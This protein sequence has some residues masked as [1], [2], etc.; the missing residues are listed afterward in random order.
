MKPETIRKI[1]DIDPRMIDFFNGIQYS[2]LNFNNENLLKLLFVLEDKPGKRISS[3]SK[4]DA[5]FAIKNQMR[6]K[7]ILLCI[8]TFLDDARLYCYYLCKARSIYPLLCIAYHLFNK[9][10][11]SFCESEEYWENNQDEFLSFKFWLYRFL[12]F[13]TDNNKKVFVLP[14]EGLLHALNAHSEELKL[15]TDDLDKCNT[16]F[17][18]Y[19]ING[20]TLF[21]KENYGHFMYPYLL[22]SY[23]YSEYDIDNVRNIEIVEE[24]DSL[25]LREVLSFVER[26]NHF[27]VNKKLYITNSLIP[28][29]ED[30]WSEERFL[31]FCEARGKLIAEKV[32]QIFLG[33]KTELPQ[34]IELENRRRELSKK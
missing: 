4:S 34:R 18:V 17:I 13:N 12:L 23:N 1:F 3:F 27:V 14:C 8:L 28:E 15:T 5:D 6:I 20:R 21:G 9:T 7:E 32:N 30:L 31:E 24:P 29:N 11:V 19:L 2:Y 33:L 10:E 16:D 25:H 26:M 22:K